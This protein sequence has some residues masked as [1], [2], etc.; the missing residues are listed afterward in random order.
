VSRLSRVVLFAADLFKLADM[1]WSVLTEKSDGAISR[2]NVGLACN[3][4]KKY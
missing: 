4:L 2:I 3:F 1:L